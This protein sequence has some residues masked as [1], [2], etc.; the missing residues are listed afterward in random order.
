MDFRR[1]RSAQPTVE[2]RPGR[3]LQALGALLRQPDLD[4]FALFDAA[5][6]LLI[7]QFRVDHALITRLTEG[8]LDTFW[9]VAAG[10]GAREPVEVQQGLRLCE[11]V[12]QEPAGCLALGS[13]FPSEGGPWLQ[14]FAGAVLREG[15]HSIGTLAI[16]HSQPY[17]F[18]DSDLEFIRSVAGLLS[19]AMEIEN[20]RYQLQVAQD[21]LALSTAVAQ[22]SAL[23]GSTTGLPNGRFLE[24]WMKGY[25]HHARRQRETL[26][27]ALWEWPGRLPEAKVL[28]KVA[29]SLRGD[30]L[31][32]EL[33]PRRFLLLL[34]QTPEDGARTLMERLRSEL[35]HPV[36]GATL[37]LPDWDDLLLNAAM[38]RAEQARQEALKEGAG[39]RW[40]APTLVALP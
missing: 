27:L 10:T 12:L 36:M 32:V 29:D 6:S 37:W 5:L 21:T 39:L 25:M 19:R 28:R 23:E 9:W 22:D 35:G 26:A 7:R 20:L 16:L 18:C 34:P 15:G 13:V 31:L 30:D 1:D 40:K 3:A 8:R 14:A 11:R 24:V 38:R 4:P 33:T 2:V 17:A